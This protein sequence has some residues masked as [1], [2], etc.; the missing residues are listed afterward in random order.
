M[1]IDGRIFTVCTKPA[2]G[3][4]FSDDWFP[5]HVKQMDKVSLSFR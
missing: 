4:L 2:E 1:K 3:G 5:I